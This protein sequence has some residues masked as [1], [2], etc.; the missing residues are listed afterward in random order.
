[1]KKLLYI[2]ILQLFSQ[3]LAATAQAPDILYYNGDTLSLFCNPLESYFDE[4]NPRPKLIVPGVNCMSTACWRGYIA[5]WQIEND[6][7]F[8]LRIEDCCQN[9]IPIKADLSLLFGDKVINGRVYAD[10]CN[11]EL[12]SPLGKLIHYEH[13]GY[14]SIY[15]KE[16]FITF[17]QGIFQFSEILDNSKSRVSEYQENSKKL[18]E[19]I[20]TNLDCTRFKQHEGENIR[21]FAHLY[22]DSLGKPDSIFIRK[23]SHPQFDAEI[24]RIIKLLP[25]WTIYYRHGKPEKSRWIVPIKILADELEQYCP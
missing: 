19:F 6:S 17:K 13:M 24:I 22:T 8:L 9:S 5:F 3:G 25:E 4:T 14:A 11:G 18:S 16:L 1:M 15:E 20:Y 23:S 21:I 2:L 10:W 7:L 12:Y